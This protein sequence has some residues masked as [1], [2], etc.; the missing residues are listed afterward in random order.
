[1]PGQVI[2]GVRLDAVGA[3]SLWLDDATSIG[4][5]GVADVNAA[6]VQPAFEAFLV[7]TP[8]G[9]EEAAIEELQTKPGVLYAEP[10]WFVKAA[11]SDEITV[12]DDGPI[13]VNDPLYRD[14]QWYLQRIF[15]SRGWRNSEIVGA[16]A[17]ATKIIRVAVVDSGIDLYHPDLDDVISFDRRNYVN[18]GQPPLDDCGH[19]THVA[20]LIGAEVNNG[21]GIAGT[22]DRVSLVP[23]K[24]LRWYDDVAVPTC[25]G[26][27]SDI[28]QA[29]EYAALNRYEII[30]LS[31]ELPYDSQTLSAAVDYAYAR[32][33]LMIA[34][35]GNCTDNCAVWFPARYKKVVG[36]AAR[37]Y[38]N[39]ITSYNPEKSGYPLDDSNMEVAGPGG[40]SIIPMLSTWSSAATSKCTT[41]LISYQGAYYCG[42]YGTS[43]AAAVV[44][45]V[46]AQ[47]WSTKPSLTADEIR[48]I[49][50]DTAIRNATLSENNRWPLVDAN[51]GVRYALP[52]QLA[53]EPQMLD[54]DLLTGA[55]SFT[56]SLDITNVSLEPMTWEI[57]GTQSVN[58]ITRTDVVSGLVSYYDPVQAHL[59]VSATHLT[60]GSYRSIFFVDGKTADGAVQEL[61]VVANLHVRKYTPPAAYLP[62][63][64]P[65]HEEPVWPYVDYHWEVPATVTPERNVYQLSQSSSVGITLPFTIT[66][67]SKLYTD[68][69]IEGAGSVLI[70]AASRPIVSL[71]S[72]LP[73][74]GS[75]GL[76]AYVFHPKLQPNVAGAQVSAFQA[77]EDRFVIEYSNVRYGYTG[78][79]RVSFQIV[80]YKNGSVGLNFARLTDIDEV[81]SAETTRVQSIDGRFYNQIACYPMFFG[82]SLRGALPTSFSSILLSQ[83]DLY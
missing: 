80:L 72:C 74:T 77:G 4:E 49:L 22:S 26:K 63:I 70:P 62:W 19:G 9:Q 8:V 51:R 67:G 39:Y 38:Y 57:T 43:M 52:S 31:L 30:N 60:S 41:R 54:L 25:G 45:G 76:A 44:S 79:R 17:L 37:D 20:G 11:G 78:D 7:S 6:M 1:M 55:P 3:A 81:D 53:V 13:Y 15:A 28:A 2:V 73:S 82:D 34:A 14:Q 48:S 32:G 50:R 27:I 29:I 5:F 65:Q 64:L 40:D 35:A 21:I 12:D 66:I 59:V 83:G 75:N 18:P 61:P 56:V 69:R 36:V 68:A 58:W 24:T 71:N 33:S 10:N 46:A 42:A 23:F 16:D 47:I